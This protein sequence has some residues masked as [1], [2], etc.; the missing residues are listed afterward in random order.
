MFHQKLKETHFILASNSP[1]RKF[2]LSQI[3][4]EAL[5]PA[6]PALDEIYPEELDKFSIPVY[7]AE[8]KSMNY[9]KR[10]GKGEILISADTIV[11]FENSV[12]NKPK[13]REDAIDIL[14]K[15]SGN[16]H[17]VITG[18]CLRSSEKKHSF[19]AKT[20]VCFTELKEDEI[21]WYVNHFKPYDKAGAYGIQEWIGYIGIQSIKGSYFNV[22]GL[23][24]QKVYSELKYFLA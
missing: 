14:S 10:L 11:W 16:T 3:G 24:V 7:L 9:K 23:P 4:I 19:S 1:R 8:L 17:E 15:L 5:V 6:L 21:I 18:V 20:E 2:L 22:M 13:D 12:I